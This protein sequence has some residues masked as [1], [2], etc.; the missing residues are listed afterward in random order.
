MP[1]YAVRNT[2]TGEVRIVNALRPESA[3]K[4]V[5]SNMF[6]VQVATA[7][8]GIDAGVQGRR[9]ER[10]GEE[11]DAPQKE[12][13]PNGAAQAWMHGQVDQQSDDAGD[14]NGNDDPPQ[15]DGSQEPDAYTE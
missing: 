9:I 7:Q 15:G 11:D 1:D 4:H 2:A 12:A 14:A 10:A 6:T 13:V 8:D 5:V 3:L